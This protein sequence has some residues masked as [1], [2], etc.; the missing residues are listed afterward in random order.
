[1]STITCTKRSYTAITSNCYS[2][3]SSTSRWMDTL[4]ML[5]SFLYRLIFLEYFIR[6]LKATVTMKERF[7]IR[8]RFV[9]YI[10]RFKNQ[11]IIVGMS[12][13]MS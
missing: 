5:V 10:K 8:I 4:D 9:G 12:N 1:M 7:G 13:Y 3:T 2:R 11:L 6:I